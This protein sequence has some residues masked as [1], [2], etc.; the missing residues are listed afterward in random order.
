MGVPID[1]HGMKATTKEW[2]VDFALDVDQSRVPG[3]EPRHRLRQPAR[4]RPQEE[5][6]VVP[7]ET[8]GMNLD[9]EPGLDLG[10]QRD[11]QSALPI[12]SERDAAPRTAIHHVVPGPRRVD[13]R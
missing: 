4:L 3:T 2:A 7:H 8:V 11:E 12:V 9:V 5:V 6:V 13:S 10:E 1:E